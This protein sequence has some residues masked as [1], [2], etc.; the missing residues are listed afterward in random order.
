MS[1]E[2]QVTVD[3]R[4]LEKALRE[5][6]QKVERWLHGFTEDLVGRIK[7]SFNTSPPGRVY[8]RGKTK[9]HTASSPGFPPNKDYGSLDGSITWEPTGSME[10]TVFV[11]VEHG[12]YLEDGAEDIGLEARPFMG[13][14]FADAQSRI[15]AD[16]AE[17][18]GLDS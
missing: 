4:G 17:N 13:P 2:M 18:L 8:R 5:D 6:P 1:S 3:T 16:A 14:A 12:E 11:G 9:T 10:T 7:L 15:E